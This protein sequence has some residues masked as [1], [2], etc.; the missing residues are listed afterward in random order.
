MAFHFILFKF[1]L[2]RV[3]RGEQLSLNPKYGE[4]WSKGTT[5]VLLKAK[6]KKLLQQNETK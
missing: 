1:S 2:E 4:Y 5:R 3:G 6:D